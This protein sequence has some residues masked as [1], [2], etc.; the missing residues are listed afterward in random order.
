MLTPLIN[1]IRIKR[2]SSQAQGEAQMTS[3]LRL[4][5]KSR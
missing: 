4:P 2:L 3:E 5:Q 1:L